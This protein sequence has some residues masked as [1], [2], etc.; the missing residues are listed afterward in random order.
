[1]LSVAKYLWLRILDV[2][3]DR[4]ESTFKEIVD[5]IL[6]TSPTTL[7]LTLKELVDQGVAKKRVSGRR[8]YYSMT[9]KGRGLGAIHQIEDLEEYLDR[10]VGEEAIRKKVMEGSEKV[11]AASSESEIANWYKGA[12]ERLDAL[13][14]E[15]TRNLVMEHCGYSCA[16]ANRSHINKAIATRKEYKSIGEFLEAEEGNLGFTREGNVIYQIYTPQKHGIRCYCSLVRGLSADQNMS[17]TYCHCSAGF[18]KKF[19]EGV[20]ER[21]V[22]VE[23]IHSVMSGAEECKFAIHL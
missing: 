17:P 8:S 6:D 20:L 4:G 23:L 16:S 21:P 11:T 10:I 7:N 19:W 2:L 5:G 3:N 18:V 13:V 9:E 1:V 12:M 14:D 22:K 15:T